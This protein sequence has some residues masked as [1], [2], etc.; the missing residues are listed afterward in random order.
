MYTLRR[1][2]PVPGTSE[3]AAEWRASKHVPACAPFFGDTVL[4][5]TAESIRI[6]APA[7]SCCFLRNESLQEYLYI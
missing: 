4:Y 1:P 7:L 2:V 3:L 5:V 6:T